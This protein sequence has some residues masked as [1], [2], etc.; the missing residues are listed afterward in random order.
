MSQAQRETVSSGLLGGIKKA[1]IGNLLVV[2]TI[3]L[4][5]I[6]TLLHEN[7][8]T[9]GNWTNITRVIAIYIIMGIG[10]TFVIT[11]GNIDLSIGSM[12]ALVGSL[13][14]TWVFEG[15]NPLFAVPLAV[16]VGSILGGLNGFVVTFLRVPAL[17]ATLGT[18]I[19]YRGAVNQYMYGSYHVRFPQSIV[20]LGQGKIGLVPV[21]LVIAVLVA[22][23]GAWY[24]HRTR[25]GSHVRA[26][27]GN[28]AAA[29]LAGVNA[30][31]VVVRAYV[32]QGALVGLASIILIGR[33][34]AAHPGVG[35]LMEL[36]VIAGVVLGG[37]LIA[38]G[39]GTIMGTVIGMLLITILENGLLLAGAGFFIQQVSLG[40][41][42]IVSVAGQQYRSKSP[43]T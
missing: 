29:G 20:V 23:V 9:V 39:V 1:L 25:Y 35:V 3:L 5:V 24:F 19:A 8:L 21:P 41:L 16:I 2:P 28:K 12:I 30:T 6:F 7:F 36:H 14:G 22:S 27:G 15:G 43:A 40:V 32:L 33:I 26:V 37:T 31:S 13:V 4:V 17:L 18:L 34:D 38:G 10:Q 42:L 11:T